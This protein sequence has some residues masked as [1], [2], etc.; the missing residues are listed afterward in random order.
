MSAS[1]IEAERRRT[2]LKKVLLIVLALLISCA[3]V[4]AVFGQTK[5]QAV[6]EWVAKAQDRFT[7]PVDV[8]ASNAKSILVKGSART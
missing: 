7:A 4:V 1:R 2:N 3:F 8:Y 5:P 6:P